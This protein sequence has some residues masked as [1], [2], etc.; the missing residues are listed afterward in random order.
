MNFRNSTFFFISQFPKFIS[1]LFFLFILC[2]SSI[3][4]SQNNPSVK[5]KK[6]WHHLSIGPVI[7][8]FKNHEMHTVNTKAKPG[9]DASYKVDILLHKKT[10][11]IIGLN[12]I[13]QGLS[14]RGYYSAPGYTYLFDKTYPYT[15]E[16]RYNE[17]QLPLYFK[18]AFNKEK[19][20]FYTAYFYGGIAFRYL[21][22]SYSVIIN[23]STSTTPYDGKGTLSFENFVFA[24]NVNANYQIG[25]GTQK[26][27]RKDGKGKS[28][29][30]EFTYRYGISRIHYEGYK[31]SNNLNIKDANLGIT[32]GFRF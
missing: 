13:S 1:A 15:H 24:K 26:N 8:F 27:F 32:F 28:M 14:F 22:N 2:T 9:F 4:Y 7:S 17:A 5:K 10:S 19:D 11:L 18:L 29:F 31:N 21:I 25:F 16:L 23:D 3:S 12:Y 30:M 6:V 20:N